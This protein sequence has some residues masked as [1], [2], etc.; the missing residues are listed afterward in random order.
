MSRRSGRIAVLAALSVGIAFLFPAPSLGDTFRIR[1]AGAFENYR[2]EPDFR[3]IVKNDRI[4]FKNPDS[5]PLHTVTA[6]GGNWRYDKTLSGG[7]KVVRRF[8]RRGVFTFRCRFHSEMKSGVCE[9]MCGEIRVRRR[10]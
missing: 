1:M 5:Q 6:Y 9:G 7:E 3:R 4:R 2:Y 8:R 10:G